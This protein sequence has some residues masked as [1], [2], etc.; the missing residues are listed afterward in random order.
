MTELFEDFSPAAPKA[1]EP[2]ADPIETIKQKFS[3]EGELDID[4]LAKAKAESDDFIKR[5]QDETA[6]LREELTKRTSLDDLITR[7]EDQ[8]SSEGESVNHT[9]KT[10]TNDDIPPNKALDPAAIEKMVEKIHTKKQMEANQVKN[11]SDIRSRLEQEWGPEFAKKL[12]SVTDELELTQDE[13]GKLA[14]EKPKAFLKLVLTSKEQS[15]NIA[16]PQSSVRMQPSS[17]GT[18]KT[19]SYYKKMMES[20]D[21]KIRNEYWSPRVQNEMH[22]LTQQLGDAFLNN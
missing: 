22:K 10:K 21:P 7:L 18:N 11:I 13:A 4:A 5:L 6:G 19:Y 1:T 8:Q 3:R 20:P 9:P 17:V 14:A 15:P 12:K 2:E 16:P